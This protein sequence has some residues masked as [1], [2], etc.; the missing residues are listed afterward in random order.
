M[1]FPSCK[2][3]CMQSGGFKTHISKRYRDGNVFCSTCNA[4]FQ[5]VLHCP[6]CGFK[7]RRRAKHRF[8]NARYR[9]RAGPPD[10]K[11]AVPDMP[12]NMLLAGEMEERDAAQGGGVQGAA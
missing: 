1:T 5:G 6:C 12:I 11:C 4:S 10:G 9:A 3:R 7:T 2:G 8:T